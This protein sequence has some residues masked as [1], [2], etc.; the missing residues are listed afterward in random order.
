MWFFN[1][2]FSHPGSY[3]LYRYTSY[4]Y[5]TGWDGWCSALA[6]AGAL[7]LVLER[8]TDDVAAHPALLHHLVNGSFPV[9]ETTETEE[10]SDP[11]S[12]AVGGRLPPILGENELKIRRPDSSSKEELAIP[13]PAHR[14][15]Q[16]GRR[17]RDPVGHNRLLGHANPEEPLLRVAGVN[18]SAGC[19]EVV[20]RSRLADHLVAAAAH[21]DGEGGDERQKGRIRKRRAHGETSAMIHSSHAPTPKIGIGVELTNVLVSIC[22]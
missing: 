8:W 14:V 10:G 20:V 1:I 12:A 16:R 5:D 7:D 13:N 17:V 9:I 18:L 22:R 11:A 2:Y 15:L 19:G 6:T 3:N 4:S 21:D